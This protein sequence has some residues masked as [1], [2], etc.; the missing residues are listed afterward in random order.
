MST[1]SPT[2][3]AYPSGALIGDN[4]VGG[5]KLVGSAGAASG[6]GIYYGNVPPQIQN[7]LTG[8]IY[9]PVYVSGYEELYTMPVSIGS[10]GGTMYVY[11]IYGNKQI[12]SDQTQ[13]IVHLLYSSVLTAG[14]KAMT[15]PSGTLYTSQG[16][17]I[18]T[19][20]SVILDSTIGAASTVLNGSA[21]VIG[22]IGNPHLGGADY[23]A[24]TFVGIAPTPP[25]GGAVNAYIRLG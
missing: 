21:T 12:D 22:T 9:P 20:F 25:N 5:T 7:I 15:S 23:I 19:G 10:E 1:Y 17:T 11:A 24:V 13:W 2:I 6:E 8:A 16:C 3:L 18:A 4:V 14:G